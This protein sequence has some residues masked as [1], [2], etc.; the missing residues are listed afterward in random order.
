MDRPLRLDLGVLVQHT[1]EVVH[2]LAWQESLIDANRLL[3]AKA[4]DGAIR[5]HY[6]PAVVRTMKDDLSGIAVGDA[7]VATAFDQGMRWLRGNVTRATLGVSLTTA[8]MQPFGLSNSIA[9]IGA[10][11]VL[12]GM[13]RWAGNAVRLESSMTDIAG[14]SDFMRLRAKNLNRELTE[15][16]GRIDG[17]SK[18]AQA[19]DAGLMYLT[20]KAQQ[21]VDV[22]T[23]LG[24]YEKALG[25]QHDEA[26]AVALAD[27]AVISSQGGGQTKDLSEVQRKN[28]MLTQFYSYFSTTANL[29]AAKTGTTSFRD[30]AAVAGWLG[31][32]ALLCAIPAL[33]PAVLKSVLQGGGGD[34]GEGWARFLAKQQAGYM[35]SMLPLVRELSG[36]IT[37]IPY[38]GPPVARIV[39]DAAKLVQQAHQGEVDEPA[40]AALARFF[41]DLTGAPMTQIVRSWKGWQAAA[42]GDA[43]ISSVLMGP[44][45]RP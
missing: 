20:A 26:T 38:A 17:K 13:A 24:A 39:T 33:G 16:S 35:L 45:A 37:G 1:N 41:G 43:P 30:P 6:G 4:V 19:I 21:V 5:A 11:P 7:A 3:G 8:L 34:D 15:I 18:T 25:E 31:D 42:H 12:R 14:K 44:P 27:E 32:M 23:W 29:I 22:P 36:T 28:P 40:V 10:G 9:R 2:N